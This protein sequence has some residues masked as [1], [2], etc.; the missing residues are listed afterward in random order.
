MCFESAQRCVHPEISF[1]PA[2][3]LQASVEEPMQH[4]QNSEAVRCAVG[5]RV[6]TVPTESGP[7]AT[8]DHH[9]QHRHPPRPHTRTHAHETPAPVNA[10]R[11]HSVRPPSF[12]GL[13]GRWKPRPP[14]D[15]FVLPALRSPRKIHATLNR[16][17]KLKVTCRVWMVYS[18]IPGARARRNMHGLDGL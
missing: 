5:T 9:P 16:P 2:C 17:V 14:S 10:T 8:V 1:T 18:G 15:S 4:M 6:H 13:P 11:P 12:R 3:N 7:A